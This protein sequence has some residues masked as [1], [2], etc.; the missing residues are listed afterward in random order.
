MVAAST[1]VCV[2][3][4]EGLDVE[5]QVYTRV[6]VGAVLNGN[7]KNENKIFHERL[8]FGGSDYAYKTPL[9]IYY[10]RGKKK[11]LLLKG[12]AARNHILHCIIY[13]VFM[14]VW[15]VYDLLYDVS[16]LAVN[17]MNTREWNDVVVAMDV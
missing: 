5:W 16:L 11:P 17:Q 14:C 10:S 12:D 13:L 3:V 7:N 4:G 15:C 2:C 9:D 8:I 6:V 1:Q